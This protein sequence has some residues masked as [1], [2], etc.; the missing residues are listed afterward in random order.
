MDV[1]SPFISVILTDSSSES[2]QT[3]CEIRCSVF[4][5]IKHAIPKTTRKA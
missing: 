3:L 4:S 5:W 2:N 1:L